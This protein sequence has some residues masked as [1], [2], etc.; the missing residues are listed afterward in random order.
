MFIQEACMK[1]LLMNYFDEKS[2]IDE[3]IRKAIIKFSFSL[4]VGNLD[5][6]YKTISS[7]NKYANQQYGPTTIRKTYSLIEPT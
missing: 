6:A 5:E 2:A 1:R 4:S 3:T 7:I